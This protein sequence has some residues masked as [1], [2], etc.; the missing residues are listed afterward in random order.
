MR[1]SL[2]LGRGPLA[3]LPSTRTPLSNHLDRYGT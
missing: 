2:A 1:S 3:N